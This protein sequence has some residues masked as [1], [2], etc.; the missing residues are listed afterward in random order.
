[1]DHE[2][3]DTHLGSTAVVQLDGLLLL[4]GLLVP[5]RSSQLSLLDL[6][7][8]SS[9]ATLDGS[10]SQKGA[11]DGLSRKLRKSSQTS[12][13]LGK[14]V[15]RGQR[16]G[17][18]VAS[19][20]HKVAKDGKHGD[21]AVLGLDEA[22]AVEALLIGVGKKSKGIPEAKGGLQKGNV[23]MMREKNVVSFR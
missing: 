18:A 11:E 9:E 22:E 20:G 12:L 19:S 4:D 21:A 5:T 7:L 1:M 16:G 10:H 15:S 6:L 2:G 17:K 14:V 13:H 3:K 8:A 23:K